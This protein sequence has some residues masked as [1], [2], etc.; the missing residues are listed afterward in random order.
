MHF[1]LDHD[2][3]ECKFLFVGEKDRKT[4][5]QRDIYFNRISVPDRLGATIHHEFGHAI[6]LEHD[7]D[8][9]RYG[10]IPFL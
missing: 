9:N 7:N 10:L 3:N 8:Y 4:E 5:T 2:F 6:G 1:N